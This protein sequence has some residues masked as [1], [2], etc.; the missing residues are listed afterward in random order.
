MCQCCL[1]YPFNLTGSIKKNVQGHKH[2]NDVSLLYRN[3]RDSSPLCQTLSCTEGLWVWRQLNAATSVESLRDV[4]HLRTSSHWWN[5]LSGDSWSAATHANVWLS[6]RGEEPNRQH[7]GCK[8]QT[9]CLPSVI[10]QMIANS[11]EFAL[12][13]WTHEAR[14]YLRMSRRTVRLL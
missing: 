11:K 1:T 2:D 7:T 3:R 8:L 5:M 4:Y 6:K 10:Q 14:Q 12:P 9:T 13:V